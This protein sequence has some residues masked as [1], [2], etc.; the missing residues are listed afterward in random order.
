MCSISLTLEVRLRSK[1]V[2]T[3]FS[4]SSG[5]RPEYSHSTLTIGMSM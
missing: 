3:R 5:D 1:L 4:I 2:T